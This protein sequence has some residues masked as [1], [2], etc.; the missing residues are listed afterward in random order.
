[1][2]NNLSRQANPFIFYYLNRPSSTYLIF[3]RLHT[4]SV[5]DIYMCF[6]TL[7]S[8]KGQSLYLKNKASTPRRIKG[9]A[10]F[11]I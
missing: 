2:E 3:P 8:A 9:K 5:P 7:S 6:V 4:Q 11:K 10:N 1:M